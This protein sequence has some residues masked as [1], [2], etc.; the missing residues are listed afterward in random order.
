MPADVPNIDV[1]PFYPPEHY[2]DFEA[3]LADLRAERRAY[4]DQFDEL[5]E[6]IK[7]SVY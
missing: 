1:D 5:D 4:L 3:E 2:D 6:E 7:E